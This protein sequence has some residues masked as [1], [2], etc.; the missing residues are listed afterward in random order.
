MGSKSCS[1][2]PQ[3]A[4]KTPPRGS[5]MTPRSPQEVPKCAQDRPKR[6]QNKHKIQRRR[7]QSVCNQAGCQDVR[8]RFQKVP[9]EAAKTLARDS[10]MS[11]RSFQESSKCNQDRLQRRQDEHKFQTRR[12]QSVCLEPIL[13]SKK[14][15]FGVFAPVSFFYQKRALIKVGD[16]FWQHGL[17]AG[18]RHSGSRQ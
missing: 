10:K 18:H 13:F 3:D 16:N 9:Q 14:S 7:L 11:P 15:L 1:R 2:C 5:K 4:A 17:R 12:L 6:H 8:S